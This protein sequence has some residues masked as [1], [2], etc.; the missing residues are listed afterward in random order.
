[1]PVYIEKEIIKEVPVPIYLNETRK[2]TVEETEQTE[3]ESTSA[4]NE[5]Q[6]SRYIPQY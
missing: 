6:F 5:T 2:E 4:L 3:K 1:M